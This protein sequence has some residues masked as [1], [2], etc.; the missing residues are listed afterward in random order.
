[1]NINLITS[2]TNNP[3]SIADHDNITIN[4]ID[5]INNSIC[6]SLVLNDVLRHLTQEQFETLLQK[7]R[8]GGRITIHSPDILEMAK[9]LYWGTID[10]SKFSSLISPAITYYS[11]IDI[12]RFLEQHNCTIEE[13]TVDVESLT[14]MVRA[15]RS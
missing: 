9:A 13:I 6:Q 5:K 4:H 8:H 12:K 10:L 11:A 1:M 14:F 7:M 3:T 15:K 2:T